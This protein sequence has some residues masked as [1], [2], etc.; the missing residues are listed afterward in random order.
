MKKGKCV[1]L[2]AVSLAIA[3]IFVSCAKKEENQPETVPPAGDEGVTS[4]VSENV[5]FGIFFDEAGTKRTL[6]LEKD[7]R[8]F[9]CWVIV[10]VP[11]DIEISAVQWQ[12]EIPEGV[13]LDVDRFNKARIMSLGQIEHSLSERF[14]PCLP[15][16]KAVIHQLTFKVTG[17]LKDAT[18]SILPAVD[19]NFL[20]ITDC[21]ERFDLI[22]ASSYKAVV[23][24][25]N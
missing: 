21:S 1:H 12:L 25:V 10:Q 19:G 8:E 2:A 15:G 6:T 23:N 4:Y 13:V 22:R 3:A 17:E 16:P 18:F 11:E 20:G 14:K 7:S 5:S 9:D 24:P